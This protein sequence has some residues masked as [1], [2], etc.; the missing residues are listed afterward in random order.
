MTTYKDKKIQIPRVF[1]L[2]SRL[3]KQE[4]YVL[5][6]AIADIGSS[7]IGTPR[8]LIFFY[9]VNL[10]Y[11]VGALP[12]LGGRNLQYIEVNIFP[13]AMFTFLGLVFK[14]HGLTFLET[15][16][17][18]H[19]CYYDTQTLK[20]LFTSRLRRGGG[21][22]SNK[23]QNY[24]NSG[25]GRCYVNANVCI[26]FFLTEH[27]VHKLLTIIT[28]FLVSLRKSSLK[29]QV[30]NLQHYQKWTLSQNF[31]KILTKNSDP[32]CSCK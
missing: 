21:G 14:M 13:V 11:P 22:G 10:I 20:E 4:S 19:V 32:L 31:S 15:V 27:L 16:L 2:E 1:S 24:A 3:L 29:L 5:P 17:M 23:M 18:M 6:T 8:S 25:E 30:S 9:P 28:R 7:C 26:W 12:I